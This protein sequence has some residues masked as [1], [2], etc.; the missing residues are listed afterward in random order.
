MIFLLTKIKKF[1]LLIKKKSDRIKKIKTE[2]KKKIV[3]SKASFSLSIIYYFMFIKL[4]IAFN[5]VNF[6]YQLC[7][8]I[9]SI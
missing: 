3:F 6:Y 9:F 8:N 5:F 4:F 7:N 2:L 1:S